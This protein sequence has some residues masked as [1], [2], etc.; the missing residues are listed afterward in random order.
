MAQKKKRN[1]R[2]V[3]KTRKPRRKGFPLGGMTG[4][5]GSMRALYQQWLAQ[6]NQGSYQQWLDT[7]GQNAGVGSGIKPITGDRSDYTPDLS[8]FDPNEFATMTAEERI[9]QLM[10]DQGL[11]R[12]EATSQQQASLDKGFDI[13][14][15]GVVTNQEFAALRD[16]GLTIRAGEAG[17]DPAKFTSDTRGSIGYDPAKGFATKSSDVEAPVIE[18]T[19]PIK[20]ETLPTQP[21]PEEAILD[22]DKVFIPSKDEDED[23]EGRGGA[24]G[25]GIRKAAQRGGRQTREASVKKAP[26][27]SPTTPEPVRPLTAGPMPPIRQPAPPTPITPTPT[28]SGNVAMGSVAQAQAPTPVSAAQM[29]PAL[30]NLKEVPTVDAVSYTHSDAADDAT[31]V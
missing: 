4:G 26:V 20:Y 16:K 2:K 15:D 23:E 12:E 1:R 28:M 17:F 11:T 30:I 27:R 9:A 19:D 24:R 29:D 5:D 14:Q 31:E 6:G 21:I 7:L 3:Y 25:G 22:E 13:N 18:K 10:K 8:D